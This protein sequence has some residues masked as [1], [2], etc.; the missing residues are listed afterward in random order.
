MAAPL[1]FS[2]V[3]AT[4]S[5]GAMPALF[6]AVA[7]L[8][9]S[10]LYCCRV[11]AHATHASRS[12][13]FHS[14]NAYAVVPYRRATAPTKSLKGDSLPRRSGR[15]VPGGSGGPPPPA[16]PPAP[17]RGAPEVGTGGRRGGGR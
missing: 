8:R 14:S 11:P 15:A 17:A 2:R 1:G 10:S 4:T 7:A 5:P 6:T 9:I 16:P 12:G 3:G 13:S